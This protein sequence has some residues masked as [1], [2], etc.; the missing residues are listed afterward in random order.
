[1]Q[2]E[3]RGARDDRLRRVAVAAAAFAIC[4]VPSIPDELRAALTE[5]QAGTFDSSTRARVEAVA[6]E[7]D[8]RYL[9]MHDDEGHPESYDPAWPAAWYSA[10][11]AAALRAAYLEDTLQAACE[12]VYEALYATTSVGSAL[13]Y[14]LLT[15][16]VASTR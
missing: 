5:V 1:M 16:V 3:L 15:S 14:E 8:E 7:L 10:R 2:A 12:A 13:E 6:E 11:A 4:A 9:D